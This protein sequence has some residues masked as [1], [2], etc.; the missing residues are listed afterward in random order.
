MLF[1]GGMDPNLNPEYNDKEMNQDYF[2]PQPNYVG[3]APSG[4]N[5]KLN[6]LAIFGCIVSFVFNFI[7]VVLCLIALGQIKKT[8]E[9][10]KGFAIL[11]IVVGIIPLIFLIFLIVFCTMFILPNEQAETTAYSTCQLVDNNGGY[12]SSELE[13]N[14]NGFV[15]CENFICTVF[16]DDKEYEYNCRDLQNFDN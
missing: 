1:N 12:E 4:S 10:G 8:G 7:G 2:E 13:S 16:Y 3:A 9:K 11:G 15:K 14:E 6:K 5:Q